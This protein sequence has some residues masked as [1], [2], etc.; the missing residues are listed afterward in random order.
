MIGRRIN[1]VFTK[2]LG[3][4]VKNV[5]KLEGLVINFGIQVKIDKIVGLIKI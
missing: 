1:V 4:H 5:R 3:G 2:T